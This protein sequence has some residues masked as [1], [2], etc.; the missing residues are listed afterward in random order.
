MRREWRVH[1][2]LGDRWMEAVAKSRQAALA[3][4]RQT[5]IALRGAYVVTE[6]MRSIV[7]LDNGQALRMYSAFQKAEGV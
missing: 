5:S 7:V 2:K 6:S 1:Q 3:H 4:A